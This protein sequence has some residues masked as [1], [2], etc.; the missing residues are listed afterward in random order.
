MTKRTK[1]AL[2]VRYLTLTPREREVISFVPLA[3]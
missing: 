2:Q 1:S 3:L